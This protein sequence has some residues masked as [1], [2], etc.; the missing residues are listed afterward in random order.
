MSSVNDW[1]ER[2]LYAEFVND[3]PE[4][5]LYVEFVNI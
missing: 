5:A 3:Q 1:P 4:R 2:A